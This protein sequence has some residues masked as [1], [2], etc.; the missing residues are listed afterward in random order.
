MPKVTFG[1]IV[2][3]GEPFTRYCLR[4]LYPFAHQIIVVEGAV[5]AA[6]NIATPDGHSSDGT[7]DTLREFKRHEDRDKKLTI[8]TAEDEGHLDGFWPGEKDEQ[9]QAYA[10][11]A[12]GDYL[13]QVD[14]DEFYKPEDMQFILKMIQDDPS[15]AAVS[16]K[17]ITF[18]GGFGYV[19]DGWYLQW[20][21]GVYHRLFK[22]G[23]GYRYVTHRP[24]TVY[25]PQGRNLRKIRWING[26]KLAERGVFLYHYSLVFPKQVVDK[27]T[28]YS[29]SDWA[30]HAG[31]ALEWAY[32]NFFS[33]KNP[34]RVHNVHQYPS[35]LERFQGQHPAEIVHLQHHI[36]D[37]R[38][39]VELRRTDDIERVLD[40]YCYMFKRAVLKMLSP[41]AKRTRQLRRL[42][43][44]LK[45]DVGGVISK[46][47]YHSSHRC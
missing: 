22:W 18:W 34:L 3:N 39:N 25:D 45:R 1:I 28:Y 29:H 11:R 40:L 35:W 36:C 37:G 23:H 19:T 41:L 43:A 8:I 4:A 46:I 26:Y 6:A 42:G 12:T 47:A 17:Q 38:I 27:C 5:P 9:S 24:P 14:V 15:I 7:L 10:R 16:F 31:E 2:L 32:S 21:A 20:G 30:S 33:L 13:W 44:R